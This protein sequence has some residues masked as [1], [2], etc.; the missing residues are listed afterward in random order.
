VPNAI[1]RIMS[2]DACKPLDLVD[3]LYALRVAEVV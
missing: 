2:E 3:A 1:R